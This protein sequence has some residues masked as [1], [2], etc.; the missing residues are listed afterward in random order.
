ML[1][2][3]GQEC[4]RSTAQARPRFWRIRTGS[5]RSARRRSERGSARRSS[6]TCPPLVSRS[7]PEN[8]GDEHDRQREVDEA[9]SDVVHAA[10]SRGSPRAYRRDYARAVIRVR[11]APSPTGP[12]TWGARSPRWRTGISRTSTAVDF[13][14]R[15]D[16][17][18][19][20]R[21]EAEAEEGILDDL[22]LARDRL[23]RGPG[24]S[25]QAGRRATP[26]SPSGMLET[27]EA[28]REEDGAVRFP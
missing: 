8:V 26:R 7:C 19:E 3:P 25:E 22:D 14:L 20:T 18:D 13:I 27:G 23:G 2:K 11:F 15:I 10:P 16:D 28:E 1:A 6:R 17:T 5:R 24:A 21:T 4:S 9:G 12:C